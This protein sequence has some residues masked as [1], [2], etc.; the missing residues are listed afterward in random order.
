M[1]HNIRKHKEP[2]EGGSDGSSTPFPRPH[3]RSV[4]LFTSAKSPAV[5]L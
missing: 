1:P 5:N 3:L 4:I 2:P